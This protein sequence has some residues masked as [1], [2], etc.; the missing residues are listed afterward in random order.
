MVLLNE[1]WQVVESTTRT[2]GAARVTYELQ[3]R[4]NPQYHSVELNRDYVEIQV[5]YS[6]NVGYIYSGTWNFSATG[7]SDVAGGGTLNGSGTLI[8]K[9]LLKFKFLLLCR[10]CISIRCY[11]IA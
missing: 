11:R 7:C 4:I 2:P 5:T 1:N 3:A 8:N 10:K 9:H 6:M